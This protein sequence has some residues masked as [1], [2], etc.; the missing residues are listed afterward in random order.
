ML[1]GGLCTLNHYLTARDEIDRGKSDL[2]M[3]IGDSI[4]EALGR[5]PIHEGDRSQE[6][7]AMQKRMRAPKTPRIFATQ[8]V[9]GARAVAS[10]GRSLDAC[11]HGR[12]FYSPE[13]GASSYDGPEFG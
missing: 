10:K 4:R 7:E 11:G 5:E 3:D 13:L 8:M 2:A 9:M 1:F 12:G 6:Y